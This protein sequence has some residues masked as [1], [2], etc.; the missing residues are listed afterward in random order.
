[1]EMIHVFILFLYLNIV[2]NEQIFYDISLDSFQQTFTKLGKGHQYIFVSPALHNKIIFYCIKINNI[3][4]NVIQS[5]K[6]LNYFSYEKAQKGYSN[7]KISL[8][9][10]E[11]NGDFTYILETKVIGNDIKYLGIELI[12]N[13]DINSLVL[14]IEI[15]NSINLIN[16]NLNKR[17]SL[18][19]IPYY[20]YINVDQNNKFDINIY[21]NYMDNIPITY[22][23]VTE[24]SSEKL[25]DK[26]I[27]TSFIL[28]NNNQY[29]FSSSY[30]I[31]NYNLNYL[32][33]AFIPDY[34]IEDFQIKVN[35]YFEDKEDKETPTNK[36]EKRDK[37]IKTGSK[38]Y[39][40]F[41]LILGAILIIIAII[42]ITRFIAKKKKKSPD[43]TNIIQE[44]PLLYDSK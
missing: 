5:I 41:L 36:E 24:Y 8:N 4:D 7:G 42:I 33:F 34:L 29:E 20:Y 10:K 14:S 44:L 9:K 12:F 25:I 21:T 16:N 18:P 30:K 13:R 32:S 15:N 19:L 2:L 11:I 6:A 1:M 3:K 37:N 38:K 43:K 40:F 17:K 39:I 22:F 35:G 26:E 31:I 28:N 27:Y 23:N